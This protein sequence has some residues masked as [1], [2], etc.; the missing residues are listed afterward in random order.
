MN[1]LRELFPCEYMSETNGYSCILVENPNCEECPNY[2]PR[3]N[4]RFYSIFKYMP[5]HPVWLFGRE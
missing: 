2:R 4:S 3:I 5:I 1:I